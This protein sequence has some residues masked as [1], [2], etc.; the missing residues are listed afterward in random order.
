M[1]GLDSQDPA[2]T[3][4]VARLRALVEARG[5]LGFNY[6]VHIGVCTRRVHRLDLLHHTPANETSEQGSLG[7]FLVAVRNHNKLN[8]RC[9]LAFCVGEKLFFGIEVVFKI[10]P[11]TTKCMVG[12][13]S[14]NN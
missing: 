3:G 7:F 2:V 11:P 9:F 1:L 10:I 6:L 13:T 4:V 5:T 8:R 14:V 12:A